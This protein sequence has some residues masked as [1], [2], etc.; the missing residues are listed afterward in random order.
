[1]TYKTLKGFISNPSGLI[2]KLFLDAEEGARFDENKVYVVRKTDES[3]LG[4][5]EIEYPA[6]RTLRG[7]SPMPHFSDRLV[8]PSELSEKTRRYLKGDKI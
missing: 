7:V 2:G 8:S 1:M 3:P 5:I 4:I 6:T